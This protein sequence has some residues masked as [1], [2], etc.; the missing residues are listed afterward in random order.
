ME[1]V[2][3][4]GDKVRGVDED[5]IEEVDFGFSWFTSNWLFWKIKIEFF[6]RLSL[7]IFLF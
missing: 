7:I 6:I 1:V 2:G 3:D 5:N 4:D